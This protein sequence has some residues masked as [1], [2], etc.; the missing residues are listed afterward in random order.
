MQLCCIVNPEPYISQFCIIITKYWNNWLIAW[1]HNFRVSALWLV[2]PIDLIL[3]HMHGRAN[4]SLNEIKRGQRTTWS[5]SRT[6]PPTSTETPQ[7]AP[8]KDSTTPTKS[9]PGDQACSTW[10]FGET[11]KIQDAAILEFRLYTDD[12]AVCCWFFGFLP[13][14]LSGWPQSRRGSAVQAP[15]VSQH[16]IR[17]MFSAINCSLLGHYANLS[18]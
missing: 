10:G 13:I 12:W 2:R 16:A 4:H 6:D 15:F 1:T 3:W 9:H 8:L 11:F 18:D 17:L 14:S 5:P 7:E